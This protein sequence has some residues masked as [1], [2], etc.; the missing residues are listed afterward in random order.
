MDFNNNLLKIQYFRHFL[1]ISLL[2]I[3]DAIGIYA[4]WPII[5]TESKSSYFNEYLNQNITIDNIEY[6]LGILI[7]ITSG[8]ARIVLNYYVSYTSE[9][10]RRKIATNTIEKLGTTCINAYKNFGK[11]LVTKIIIT[12]VDNIMNYRLRPILAIFAYGMTS[13]LIISLLLLQDSELTFISIILLLSFYFIIYS[14]TRNRF[15]HYGKKQ[16]DLNLKRYQIIEA[17]YEKFEKI[18]TAGKHQRI[19]NLFDD[20]GLEL[21]RVNA[22]NT[23][24]ASMPRHVLE[25]L[26]IGSLLLIFFFKST[27]NLEISQS[28]LAVFGLATIKIIPLLQGIFQSIANLK[29]G[30][31]SSNKVQSLLELD[32]AHRVNE[33][34]ENV[35]NGVIM[36]V[37]D[38]SIDGTPLF[39]GFN[40]TL[41][42]GNLYFVTGSSGSGKTTLMRHMSSLTKKEN[43]RFYD[44]NLKKINPYFVYQSNKSYVLPL[45][46]DDNLKWFS[47][48]QVSESFLEHL[49]LQLNFDASVITNLKSKEILLNDML[50]AGQLQ[51][52]EIIQTLLCDV[53]LYFFDEPTSNLDELNKIAVVNKLMEFTNIHKKII[54]IVTHDID[55]FGDIG[56][57]NVL[58]KTSS[59]IKI[60]CLEQN[61]T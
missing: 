17:N 35:S 47:E 29:F 18:V 34:K 24:W 54:V 21:A 36:E 57:L 40:L 6:I 44:F 11:E 56:K 2:S 45:S 13:I 20:V 14:L 53:D 4:L 27:A 59:G 8:L 3:L 30:Y 61:V 12:D 55:V 48:N 49:L 19:R 39:S 22:L 38:I 32:R 9:N 1:I 58:H 52:L 16:S 42:K 5:Q 37:D 60:S 46:L 50:S 28:T 41:T 23:H 10:M 43:V 33:D 7:L 26:V 25:I 31:T 51:R 15:K